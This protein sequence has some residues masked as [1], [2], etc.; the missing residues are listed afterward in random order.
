MSPEDADL[1][2]KVSAQKKPHD[3]LPVEGLIWMY[4]EEDTLSD[5]MRQ[6]A[7]SMSTLG[8]SLLPIATPLSTIMHRDNGRISFEVPRIHF[9]YILLFCLW[10]RGGLHGWL[11]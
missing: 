2:K 1:P 9:Q 10:F 6:S 5:D 11:T 4:T 8:T 7:T 3:D